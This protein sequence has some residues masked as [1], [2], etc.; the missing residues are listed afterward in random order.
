MNKLVR[1]VGATTWL[2]AALAIGCGD[3]TSA[4]GGS[5]TGAS[6]SGGNGTGATGAGTSSGG[7][8]TGGAAVGGAAAGGAAAGGAAAT[9]GSNTGGAGGAFTGGCP[10]VVGSCL[11]S[12]GVC[13]DYGVGGLDPSGC[14]NAGFVWLAESC[15]TRADA[16][17]GAGC[18]GMGPPY[19]AVFWY[20]KSSEAAYPGFQ[21]TC[22]NSGQ[23]WIVL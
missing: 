14:T 17:V 5:G 12:T 8:G 23:T 15:V 22:E 13:S 19:C 10:D 6:N 1:D 4:T 2:L 21:M 7:N 20:P 16:D 3:D 18:L 9:G 11:A